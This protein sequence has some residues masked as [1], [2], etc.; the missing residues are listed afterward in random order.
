MKI[1]KERRDENELRHLKKTSRLGWQR[2]MTFRINPQKTGPLKMAGPEL[3]HRL[4]ITTFFV[5]ETLASPAFSKES[6]ISVDWK[7]RDF[8]SLWSR[9]PSWARPHLLYGYQSSPSTSHGFDTRPGRDMDSL[10]H[11]IYHD[12]GKSICSNKARWSARLRAW[13]LPRLVYLGEMILHL[14]S[15][16][17]LISTA[18]LL[19]SWCTPAS[20]LSRMYS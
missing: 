17:S 20:Q 14:I 16:T 4:R 12:R 13:R 18:D 7:C 2:W 19:Y 9:N 5:P 3:V 10:C 1:R 6:F 11:R 8:S 15:S